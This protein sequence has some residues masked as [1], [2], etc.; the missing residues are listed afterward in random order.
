MD[1]FKSINYDILFDI[2]SGI[3]LDP[4]IEM[5]E[6]E[7]NNYISSLLDNGDKKEKEEIKNKV[8]KFLRSKNQ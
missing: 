3:E 5:T 7:F 1:S 8:K 2:F 4:I 6:D